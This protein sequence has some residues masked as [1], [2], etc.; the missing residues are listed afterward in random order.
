MEHEQLTWSQG[1]AAFA[2]LR[3]F[4]GYRLNGRE[5]SAPM[6]DTDTADASSDASEAA[7]AASASDESAGGQADSSSAASA[8]Q[9]GL[10]D[11]T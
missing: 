11:G 9:G 10:T 1:S 8:S 6:A 4:F 5:S 2:G 7:S 3:R